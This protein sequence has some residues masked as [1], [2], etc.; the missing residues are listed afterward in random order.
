MNRSP[1]SRLSHMLGLKTALSMALSAPWSTEPGSPSTWGQKA[2]PSRAAGSSSPP[3]QLPPALPFPAG[4]ATDMSK[5][6]RLRSTPWSWKS[7]G[8]D[9]CS[10]SSMALPG[11]IARRICC[12]S[13]RGNLAEG[14]VGAGPT[15]TPGAPIIL[16][17]PATAPGADT[18]ATAAPGAAAS[19]AG[20]SGGTADM[21]AMIA[22]VDRRL[23]SD[24]PAMAG[25]ARAALTGAAALNLKRSSPNWTPPYTLRVLVQMPSCEA[26]ISPSCRRT[27]ERQWSLQSFGI[28]R[29]QPAAASFTADHSTRLNQESSSSRW[30]ASMSFAR[31]EALASS[32]RW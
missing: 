2:L 19:G 6:S 4:V 11:G 7:L 15:W 3:H 22:K 13:C 10:P 16:G 31:S 1:S 27:S 9:I 12:A 30:V 26:T 23:A 29:R 14:F 20:A 17:S 18:A 21:E 5:L 25:G 24:T 28:S 8:R 32:R